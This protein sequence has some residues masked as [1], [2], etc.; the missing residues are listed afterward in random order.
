MTDIL[1]HHYPN[2]PF[3]G[4]FG[5]RAAY[6]ERSDTLMIIR[7]NPTDNQAAILSFP[8][9]MWVEQAGSTRHGRIN[10]NFDKNLTWLLDDIT[11]LLDDN[12]VGTTLREAIVEANSSPGADTI[13][14]QSG[15]SGTITLT[16][17][18][19]AIDDDVTIT[20]PGSGSLTVDADGA[21]R[22]FLLYLYLG[23]FEVNISGLTITGGAPPNNNGAGIYGHNVELSLDDVVLDDNDAGTGYGGGIFI[24][25][26]GSTLAITDSTISGNSASYGGAVYVNELA[27]DSVFLISDSV[28]SD[29]SSTTHASGFYMGVNGNYD[30]TIERS[31]LS[32]NTT[33]GDGSVGEFKVRAGTEM[34]IIDDLTAYVNR[35]YGEH[36]KKEKLECLDAWIARGTAATTCID[37]AEKYLWR[38]GKKNGNNKDDLM[39]VLHYTLM[40]LYNDHYKG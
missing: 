12:G 9:D 3:A 6:G 17:G 21:S 30:V 13:V 40:C 26:S 27:N 22:A 8:R 25:G 39:K 10:S 32:G 16:G 18:Q 34:K 5:N 20:G 33:N 14:F 37:T 7:V 1:L 11:S 29:N 24:G 31:L 4:G 38:Y 2:S 28:I 19:L 15:V 35:T 36:Y 23:S